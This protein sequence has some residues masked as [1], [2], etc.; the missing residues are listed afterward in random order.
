N[1]TV[2]N[3]VV[4]VAK[5]PSAA[6]NVT[7]GVYDGNVSKPPVA[8]TTISSI[9]P[10]SNVT[11]SLNI[12]L[13]GVGNHTLIFYVDPGNYTNPEGA[14]N[15]YNESDN[16]VYIEVNV[17]LPLLN[18]LITSPEA[19]KIF[20]IGGNAIVV[21][22]RI[23]PVP[24]NLSAVSVSVLVYKEG[25][26][27]SNISGV[28]PDASGVFYAYLGVPSDTGPYTIKAVVNYKGGIYES[29]AVNIVVKK[30][31]IAV[32]TP[33]WVYIAI[34]IVIAAVFGATSWYMYRYGL[35][36]FVECGEC[37][38]IIP[39]GSKKCPKCGIEFE[40]D[41]A[42]CSVCGAWIPADSEVC[43]ECGAEFVV[44]LEK[45]KEYRELMRAKYEEMLDKYREIAKKELG[46]EYSEEKFAEWWKNHPDYIS[47]DAWL[48]LQEE[49]R[50]KPIKC[51]QC[52]T[53]NPST[54][55]IC[56]KCGSP[57]PAPRVE[58]E[59][60][61][62]EVKEVPEAPKVPKPPEKPKIE[63]KP[64][65][66]KAKEAPP[67]PTAPPE[68]GAPPRIPAPKAPTP[69]VEA[70]KPEAPK[71][72]VPEAE[73]K[74][75]PVVPKKVIK[76]EGPAEVPPKR[77]VIKR[78]VKKHVVAKKVV[79]KKPIKPKKEEEEKE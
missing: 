24:S 22:G 3:V 32:K 65:A 66:A 62:E 26:L 17:G 5:E 53:L 23:S 13:R 40:K 46:P 19:N 44:A 42:K 9:G 72:P 56:H 25:K 37:G 21:S 36:K 33:W 45:E 1:I 54:A 58:E 77:V 18:V 38:A 52:G 2:H 10:M 8:N 29:E 67:K 34:A 69:K 59:K 68:R 7:I 51:P 79:V 78:P 48:I 31:P 64:P 55:T 11:V 14:V 35:G 70:A 43:P 76:R 47:F 57:L 71:A 73:K 39:A 49:K 12:T 27:Y 28:S 50:G 15:E 74:E 75:V 16:M 61:P 41:T 60:P 30:A 20:E 63:E 6:K 4:A